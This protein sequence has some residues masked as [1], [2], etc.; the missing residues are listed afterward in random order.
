VTPREWPVSVAASAFTTPLNAGAFADR[1]RW[2]RRR[3]FGVGE[4]LTPS[5]IT[6]SGGQNAAAP[7]GNDGPRRW[8]TL[9]TKPDH[10]GIRHDL[11]P[12]DAPVATAPGERLFPTAWAYLQAEGQ[13]FESSVL[14]SSLIRL[15]ISLTWAA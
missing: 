14:S 11:T 15:T 9:T 1:H 3:A 10:N 8:P 2:S 5:M 4:E 6:E 12:A 13:G 7:S